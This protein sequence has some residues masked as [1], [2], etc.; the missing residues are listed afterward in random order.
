M[1]PFSRPKRT[2]TP[3]RPLTA[4]QERSLVALA[5]LCPG[6]GEEASA[7][8]VGERSGIRH[9]ATTLALRGLERRRLVACHGDDEPRM[10]APTLPG[11]ALAKHLRGSVREPRVERHEDDEPA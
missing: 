1:Q 11:R 10:Y 7:A 5:E 9:G 4:A 8:Q 6:L 2:S 3:Q